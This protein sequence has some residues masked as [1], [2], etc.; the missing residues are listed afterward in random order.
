MPRLVRAGGTRVILVRW[1]WRRQFDGW[2]ALGSSGQLGPY[3]EGLSTQESLEGVI[4]AT[5]SHGCGRG[6][7]NE[8]CEVRESMSPGNG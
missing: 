6:G 4:V 1:S 2:S 7:H 3:L 5:G 8:G